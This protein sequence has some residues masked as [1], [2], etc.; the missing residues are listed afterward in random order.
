MEDIDKT[1][2]VIVNWIQNNLNQTR[3]SQTSM[4]LPEIIKALAELVLAREHINKI[5]VEE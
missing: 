4:I 2:N 3:G 5:G 1:I